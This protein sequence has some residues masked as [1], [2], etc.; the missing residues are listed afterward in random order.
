M[1]VLPSTGFH[2]QRG[3]NPLASKSDHQDNAHREDLVHNGPSLQMM[4]RSSL[5]ADEKEDQDIHGDGSTTRQEAEVFIEEMNTN[6]YA[7][8]VEDSLTVFSLGRLRDELCCSCTWKSRENPEAEAPFRAA[9]RVAHSCHCKCGCWTP[10]PVT[11][12]FAR[13]QPFT[14]GV[15]DPPETTVTQVGGRFDASTQRLCANQQTQRVHPS[16][17]RSDL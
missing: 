7:K 9:P 10:L 2:R 16:A 8:L 4:C 3:G 5:S 6:V 13:G 12:V 11:K 15:V 1:I 17:R 14:E